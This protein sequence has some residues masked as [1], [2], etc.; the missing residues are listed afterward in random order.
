MN[1]GNS[2]KNQFVQDVA[3]AL[4]TGQITSETLSETVVWL[5]PSPSTLNGRT[6]IINHARS[7]AKPQTVRILSA[8]SHGKVGMANGET[9]L[10]GGE[11]RR[12]CHVIE[13]TNSKATTVALIQTYD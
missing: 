2:P 13:F 5:G 8:I 3:I 6:A 1:C 7:R 9:T 12:F 4:E 11:V 10:K